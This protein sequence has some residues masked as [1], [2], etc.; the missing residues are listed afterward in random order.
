MYA[1]IDRHDVKA[2]N[3]LDKRRRMKYDAH[4]K[5]KRNAEELRAEREEVDTAEGRHEDELSWAYDS[6]LTG[7][8]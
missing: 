7:Y 3:R 8:R 5:G 1:N 4:K 6:N 2:L